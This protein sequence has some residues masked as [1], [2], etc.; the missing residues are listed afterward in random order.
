VLLAQLSDTH[1]V[2]RGSTYFGH[3]T[4]RYLSDAIGAL[5]ALEPR[6][7]LVAFTGDLVNFGLDAE[8]DRFAEV[9]SELRIPYV[10]VP[11]NHDDR[12]R[13]RAR[14]GGGP[15]ARGERVRFA[16]DVGGARVIGLDATGPRFWPGGSLDPASLA[17]L[18]GTLAGDPDTPTIVCIHQPPF[19]TGL[20]YLDALGF[21]GA[22]RF[23]R[24]IERHPSV[25]RIVCGHIHCVRSARIGGAL[26]LSAPS[27]A[28]QTVPELFERRVFA[29]RHEV[30]GFALHAWTAAQGFRSTVFRRDPEG[31]Y[32]ES[33]TL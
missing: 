25:G 14:L 32:V 5:H 13:M 33:A 21:P 30:P 9:V 8:Y 10:A 12:D 1:L 27:T 11:G 15:L 31:R 2:R 3:D 19:R 28:P 4:D 22:R 18:E 24:S 29:M 20:H 6:P 17:W 7:D 23:A 16:L 26:A